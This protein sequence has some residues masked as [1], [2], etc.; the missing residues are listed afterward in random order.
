MGVHGL[1]T[2]L[3]ENIRTLSTPLVLSQDRSD[4]KPTLPLVIDGWS[5]VRLIDTRCVTSSITPSIASYINYIIDLACLG[6]MVA[7]LGSSETL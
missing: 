7:N 2:Y 5:C 3:K 4:T 1:A 6:Y